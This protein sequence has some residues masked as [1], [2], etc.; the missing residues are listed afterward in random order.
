MGEGWL[1]DGKHASF[2]H[3]LPF[4]FYCIRTVASSRYLIDDDIGDVV[5]LGVIRVLV[6]VAVAVRVAVR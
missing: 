1:E 2:L 6:R 3:L 5:L 4:G